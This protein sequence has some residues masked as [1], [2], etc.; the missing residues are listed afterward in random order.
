MR[1][2]D[3]LFGVIASDTGSVMADRFTAKGGS[4]TVRG[5][6]V[7]GPHAYL[8]NHAKES[9]KVFLPFDEHP[10]LLLPGVT[11]VLQASNPLTS[12]LAN[13]TV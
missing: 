2:E 11:V 3:C 9:R 12:E 13:W 6:K 1:A 5:R 4:L 8:Q 10:V 7:R